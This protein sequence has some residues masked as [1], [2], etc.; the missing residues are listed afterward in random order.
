MNILQSESDVK[1]NFSVSH[2]GS[3]YEGSRENYGHYKDAIV[4]I[5]RWKK[6]GTT[7]LHREHLVQLRN[8]RFWYS[9]QNYEYNAVT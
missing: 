5:K 2:D 9:S 8:V 6:L 3:V 4:T 1:T 7:V